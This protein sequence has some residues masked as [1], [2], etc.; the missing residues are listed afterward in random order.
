MFLISFSLFLHYSF[1]SFICLAIL[2][3]SLFIFFPIFFFFDHGFFSFSFFPECVFPFHFLFFF[4]STRWY[5]ES[6]LPSPFPFFIYILTLILS[7]VPLFLFFKLQLILPFLHL[8]VHCFLTFIF[9]SWILERQQSFILRRS[10]VKI[11]LM[12]KSQT[13]SEVISQDN[14]CVLV[15]LSVIFI[16]LSNSV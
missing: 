6:V 9:I 15:L 10:M 5:S 2:S 14:V 12:E 8:F 13:G 1:H 3:L 16:Q 4:T 7:F 11:N